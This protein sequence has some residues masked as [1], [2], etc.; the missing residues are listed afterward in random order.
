MF[1]F[2]HIEVMLIFQVKLMNAFLMIYMNLCWI[3]LN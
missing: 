1:Y 3:E 2:G